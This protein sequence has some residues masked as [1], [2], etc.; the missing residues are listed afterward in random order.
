MEQCLH[1]VRTA[2]KNVS[3]E[4]F[5]VDNNSVDGSVRMVK[6]KFPEVHLIENKKNAGFSFANNQAIRIANG[7]YVLLLNPDTVVEEDTFIKTIKFMDEYPDAGGLGVKML[8]GKGNF[9]PESK[10]GLPTPSVAFYK[11]FGLATLFPN[12]KLFGRYH[13]GFLDNDKISEV[14]VLAGA[15]MMLR[16]S[17]LDRIGLLDETFFMYGED[18]DIS[19]RIT[20]AG[21]K[22][23]YFPETR[24]IHYKGESTRKSSINYVFVFYN[25]MI[26]F[27]QK[28]F[29]Q[30]HAKL[31]SFLIHIAIYIRAGMAIFRR[32]AV[33]M[34]LPILDAAIVMGGLLF[35]K[36][37]YEKN[38]RYAEVTGSYLESLVYIAFSCYLIIWI[39]AI[40][41]NGGYD[42]PIRLS[43]LARGILIGT[44]IILIIYSLLPEIYRFSRA[45]ILIGAAWALTSTT[46]LRLLLHVF[47]IKPYR[48]SE[49]ESKRIVIIG[50]LEESDRVHQLLKQTTIKTSF[51][52][53]IS[54]NKA[55][56]NNKYNIGSIEQLPDYIKIYEI[57]EIIFCAKDIA[58]QQIIS[59]MLQMGNAQV[60]YKIAPPESLSVIGS[61]SI[62]TS[63]DLYTIDVN[64]ITKPE[65]RRLKR[66]FDLVTGLVFIPF[67]V[68]MIPFIK[69]PLLFFRNIVLVLLGKKSWIGYTDHETLPAVKRG[70]LT[71]SVVLGKNLNKETADRIDMLY[72]KDYKLSNDFK[73]LFRGFKDLGS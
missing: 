37:Y 14:D 22:N 36:D 21:Y 46:G 57:D 25:A 67:F 44:G 31:F 38:V 72:A 48:L 39:M 41:L 69:Q 65:N 73:I 6:E 53:Y 54:T 52:G 66:T 7:E 33:A 8:D 63:G 4:V 49:N 64:S 26:I 16:K 40:Y 20:Q 28:H 60:D 51:V 70:V 2:L 9:L 10:R 18:I 43:K 17:V 24:I 12:S 45:L 30:N 32:M 15:F 58:A 3:S 71:P 19:F 50:S 68:F 42:K 56:V 61:N 27:A 13:L 11:V 34:T 47:D 1:S 55:D 59:L 35:I 29:S 62:D 23:Y 5:V